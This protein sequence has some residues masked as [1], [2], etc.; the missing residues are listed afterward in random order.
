MVFE[1]IVAVLERAFKLELSVVQDATVFEVASEDGST[2]VQVLLQSVSERKLVLLSADLGEPPSEGCEKLFRTMLEANNL[3]S[4]TAG[5]TLALDQTSGRF[6]LQKYESPDELANDA[7]GKLVSFIETAL[8][9]SRSIADFRPSNEEGDSPGDFGAIQRLPG[10]CRKGGPDMPIVHLDGLNISLDK[11]NEVADGKYN[12]GQLK[13]SEDGKSVYR[14]NN[15]KTWTIFNSTKISPEESLAIKQAFCNALSNEGLAQDKIDYVKRSLG[16]FGSKLELLKFGN[17]KPLSAAEV[18]EII[19]MYAG[20][21]N[22]KRMSAAKGTEAAKMLKTSADIY[23]GVS[24]KTM[25][26][27]E[28]TRGRI[29]ARTLDKI[30]TGADWS[31]NRLMDIL[32]YPKNGGTVSEET[33][34]IA[35]EFCL[36]MQSKPTLLTRGNRSIE[37]EDAFIKL[38]LEYNDKISA[39][40]GLGGGRVF[41]IDTGLTKS[42]LHALMRKVAGL[43]EK[44]EE[45]GNER[46]V[47]A[48]DV[49]ERNKKLLEDLSLL[50]ELV[51]DQDAYNAEVSEVAANLK[52][53]NGLKLTEEDR[54]NHAKLKWRDKRMDPIVTKLSMA[55][56]EARGFDDRNV[57]LV[58]DVREVCYGNKVIDAKKLLD[59]ISDVLFKKPAD[60]KKSAHAGRNADPLK[61]VDDAKLKNQIDDLGENLNINA[62]LNGN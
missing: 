22:A 35:L 43:P 58:N 54:L 26:D 59:D 46:K 1:D 17:I 37:L 25:E 4:G 52:P 5:A 42:E 12:I 38:K 49:K 44:I 50:F 39:D 40:I 48:K 27:R 11:F 32:E 24:K 10:R 21:I 9:W 30:Q 62:I 56:T 55:L 61:N 7:E 45:T 13:L 31:V 18:R 57:K 29:N 47:G 34:G 33:K 19:D 28:T 8:V 3:F 53:R 51:N 20:E 16:I 23:N 60:P 6:R 14:T 2:K 36:A 15:H 41:N